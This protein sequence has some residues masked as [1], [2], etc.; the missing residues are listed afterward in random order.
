[1]DQRD[2][3]GLFPARPL[4]RNALYSQPS[5]TVLRRKM[6]GRTTHKLRVSDDRTVTIC[7]NG[8]SVDI[9]ADSRIYFLHDGRFA[10]SRQ[11]KMDFL[12]ALEN[13]KKPPGRRRGLSF[14]GLL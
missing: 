11:E 7:V 4:L 3:T 9:D 6:R 8:K 1:M 13:F 12:T 2:T 5:Q 14:L 10:A